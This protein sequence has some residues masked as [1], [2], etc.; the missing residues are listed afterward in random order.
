MSPTIQRMPPADPVELSSI[1]NSTRAAALAGT[2]C[3]CSGGL[4]LAPSQV[5]CL[6]ISPLRSNAGLEIAIWPAAG[7]GSSPLEPEALD[8]P[9]PEERV[10]LDPERLAEELA[11]LEEL[12]VTARFSGLP[13]YSEQSSITYPALQVVWLFQ[14]R[15]KTCSKLARMRLCWELLLAAVIFAAIRDLSSSTLTIASRSAS[16]SP[17]LARNFC[18]E[19]A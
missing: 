13:L 18:N 12:P 8:A 7:A 11:E 17:D 19:P 4:I 14:R 3:H 16:L 5:Y 1:T 9:A 6:G 10:A 15:W 2:F